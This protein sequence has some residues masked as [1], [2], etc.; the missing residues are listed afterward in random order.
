MFIAPVSRLIGFGTTSPIFLILGFSVI[1]VVTVRY[2]I[3]L[4]MLGFERAAS[5][6]VSRGAVKIGRSGTSANCAH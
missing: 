2:R 1:A 3:L 6:L 5:R 4:V